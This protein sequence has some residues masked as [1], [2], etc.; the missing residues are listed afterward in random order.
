M[1][2]TNRMRKIYESR[3]FW[4]I[5]SLLASLAIWIYV[6]GVEQEEF[7]QTFRGVKVELVGEDILRTSKNM[8]VTDLDISTVTIDVVGPRRIIGSLDSDDLRAEIDVSK[9][10]Q[11]AYTSQRYDVQF[12]NGTDTRGVSITRKMPETINFMVSQQTYK[13]VPVRG[14]FDGELAESYTAETPVFEPSTITVTGPEAYIK[15]ISYA[16]VSFGEDNIET[17]YTVETG[18]TLM[19]SAGEPCSTTGLSFSS[20]TVKATLPILQI[21]EV[22]LDVNLIEGSGATAENTIVTVEPKNL[23]I[24]G[25]SAILAGINKIVLTTI[26]LTDFASTFTETYTIPLSNDVKNL[27]GVTEAKVTIEIVGLETKT[28]KISN[29]SCI[30]ITDGYTAEILTESLDV[31]LRGTK[32]QLESVKSENIRAVADLIDYDES[33]GAFM[34]TVKIYI[35]G[36]TGIGAV[37]EYPISVEMHKVK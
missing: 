7:K 23:S 19:N 28:F 37:G 29:F 30:N 8:V 27:T 13:T 31:T 4:A 12:P 25:D 24:V 35:D 16:W 22:K 32:E 10:T 9:L 11:A 1:K 15:D 34:P 2:N 17:T 36:T 20:D 5:I 14:S 33:S 18:Y 6:T 21:K 3:V 26:D